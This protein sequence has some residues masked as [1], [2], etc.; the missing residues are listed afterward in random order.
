M[1][2]DPPVGLTRV[3][4]SPAFFRLLDRNTQMAIAFRPNWD[5]LRNSGAHYSPVEESGKYHTVKSAQ[6]R[7]PLESVAGDGLAGTR[8]NQHS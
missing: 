6:N 8:E 2:L 4:M 7:A 3:R 5:W 1:V